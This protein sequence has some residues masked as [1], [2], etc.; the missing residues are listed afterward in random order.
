MVNKN[1]EIKHSIKLTDNAAKKI[2]SLISKEITP[3]SKLRISVEGGGCSGFKYNY[4]FVSTQ[5]N[6]DV[7]IER[8]GA[9]VLID[10]IS[11]QFMNNI[12]IDYVETLTSAQ[13]EIINPNAS[14][15]CGCG[16]SFSV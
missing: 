15:K 16:N 2:A 14:T 10:E 5:K 1:E 9:V 3:N 6:D 7:V 8:D 12:I 11:L 13:F 4:H